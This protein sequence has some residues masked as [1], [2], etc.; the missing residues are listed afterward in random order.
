[1]FHKLFLLFTDTEIQEDELNVIDDKLVSEPTDSVA[2]ETQIL[3]EKPEKS[4]KSRKPKGM[5]RLRKQ[6]KDYNKEAMMAK[7]QVCS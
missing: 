4:V 3:P 6:H 5:S 1:M 2:E 7:L